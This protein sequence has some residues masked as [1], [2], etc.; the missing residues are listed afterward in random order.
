MTINP[1]RGAREFFRRKASTDF[2]ENKLYTYSASDKVLTYGEL[3]IYRYVWKIFPLY[4]FSSIRRIFLTEVIENW[5]KRLSENIQNYL[6]VFYNSFSKTATT[7][8]QEKA[9]GLAKKMDEEFSSLFQQ[10]H[11]SVIDTKVKDI[12][13]Q[14]NIKYRKLLLE[15]LA[16]VTKDVFIN[17][18][19]RQLASLVLK[20]KEELAG[21]SAKA[22]LCTGTNALPNGT[23]FLFQRG[24]EE[25]YVI[26]QSPQVHTT[27]FNRPSENRTYSLAFPFIV[28]FIGIKNKNV[29]TV[30]VFFRNK[31]L[32]TLQDQLLCPALP[33]I[34]EDFRVCFPRP[35]KK[36]VPSQLVEE[37]IN[38]FWGSTFNSDLQAFFIA[39]K[40]SID[41]VSS[42]RKWQEESSKNRLF[43]VSVKW[44]SAN[45]SV[46][47]CVEKTFTEISGNN[48]ATQ[49]S[50]GDTLNTLEKHVSDLGED[51]GVK[52]QE[53]ALTILSFWHIDDS[54]TTILQNLF[55]ETIKKTESFWEEK[56]RETIAA[57]FLDEEIEE[58]TTEAVQQVSVHINESIQ[59]TTTAAAQAIVHTLT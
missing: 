16:A 52:I 6:N 41:A 34:H 25:V 8:F 27:S 50:A 2:S 3:K 57:L 31:P 18:T 39:A 26:E 49:G 38:N 5:N 55:T 48:D 37:V 24:E 4:A 43:G 32:E 51:L 30:R 40:S 23:R 10:N 29:H 35:Q 28:F 56:V 47:R 7:L 46:E 12:V 22:P 17:H 1:F 58:V 44:Q 14:E 11:F 53:A 59:K 15:K 19:K 9:T 45:K 42:L 54:E 20:M 36:G 33:N 21:A 13:R